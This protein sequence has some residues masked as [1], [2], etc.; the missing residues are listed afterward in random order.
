M[1]S[2]SLP[3]A[4]DGFGLGLVLELCPEGAGV[5]P[6]GAGVVGLGVNWTVDAAAQFSIVFADS[7]RANR[8]VR[9]L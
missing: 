1:V 7:H 6:E 2:N 4:P 5:C 9:P 3:A 8:P